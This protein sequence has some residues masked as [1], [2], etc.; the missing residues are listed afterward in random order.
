MGAIQNDLNLLQPYVKERVVKLLAAMRAR[1]FDPEVF[2]TYRS[3]ARQRALMSRGPN[4]TRT[5]KSKH[6]TG[7]AVDII[8]KS[9]HWH[10]EAFFKALAEEARSVGLHTLRFEGCH[11]EWRG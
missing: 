7:K 8:S 9:R 1:G 10:W 2:E 6:L 5:L 11:V 4:T 3:P